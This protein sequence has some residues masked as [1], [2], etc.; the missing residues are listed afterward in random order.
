[1][2]YSPVH[3]FMFIFR[4]FLQQLPE[5]CSTY[6][7]NIK[8]KIEDTGSIEHFTT[9]DNKAINWDSAKQVKRVLNDGCPMVPTKK[10]KEEYLGVRLL[11]LGAH[12]Q[13]GYCTCLVCLSV[14]Y[15]IIVDIVRFYGLPKVRTVLF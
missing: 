2:A 12:A 9:L 7:A 11:T 1:M 3:V 15:H 10:K 4:L 6:P 13:E 14:C 5:V 8:S